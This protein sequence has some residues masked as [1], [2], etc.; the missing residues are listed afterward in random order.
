MFQTI[1]HSFAKA[2]G[3]TIVGMLI[4]HLCCKIFAKREVKTIDKIH[5]SV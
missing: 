5:E 1:Q 2:V 3:S 4:Q